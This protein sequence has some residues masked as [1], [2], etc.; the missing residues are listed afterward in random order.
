MS[1]YYDARA[2]RTVA[3]AEAE[4]TRAA[5]EATRA[6]TEL[7]LERE[8]R[9]MRR[10][11][12]D[13]ERRDRAERAVDKAMRHKD[14][15]ARL[16][17]GAGALAAAV[18]DRAPL[19][20][21]GVAMSAPIVLAWSGQMAFAREVMHLG[22]LAPTL[23]I[24]LEGS[25][26]YVA[27]LTH[28]AIRAHLP[29]GRYRA[30]TWA[31]AAVAAGM[32][33]WHGAQS[34]GK[35]GVQ[36]GVALALASLLGIALWELTASLSARSESKRSA[37]EIR[38]AAWRRVR[39]PR[40]SY[41]AAS[42]RAARGEACTVDAAWD[43]AWVDRFG[44]GPQASR[45]DRRL[46]RRIVATQRKADSAAA[47]NG[48]LTIVDG[49]ITRPGAMTAEQEAAGAQA[50]AEF[51]AWKQRPRAFAARTDTPAGVE[52]AV[53]RK[54]L[55]APVRI[56]EP[57]MDGARTK[58]GASRT[59][60]A[61]TETRTGS[62]RTDGVGTGTGES[63]TAVP[64]DRDAVIGELIQEILAAASRGETWTPD[65]AALE[66]RYDRRRSWCEKAVRDARTAVARTDGDAP[67]AGESI[68]A[69]TGTDDSEQGGAQAAEPRTRHDRT[70]DQTQDVRSDEAPR[71]EDSDSEDVAA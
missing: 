11:A 5:A 64:V 38:R 4:A 33:A 50:I 53:S 23:P 15:T 6:E 49:Q 3:S 46:A 20:L 52:G 55:P 67:P 29:I 61:R 48:A 25:V 41:A 8:R 43:A 70:D 42:I 71:T 65:Y 66:N 27:Y 10:E 13:D 26:W 28:R 1:T 44:V 24:A 47:K 51:T 37:A 32:N 56:P 7:R 19:M 16:R 9:Q 69:G 34:F 2:A 54:A 45:R 12:M 60:G 39:Y 57:R 36:V 31:L 63:R 62:A 35:D 22:V 17:K 40:L 14:R 21:G 68:G 58:A 59:D 30:A 18:V